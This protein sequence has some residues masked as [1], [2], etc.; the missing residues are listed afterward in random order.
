M[1]RIFL[2]L[3]LLV[4]FGACQVKPQ[5]INYGSDSCHFCK[6]TIVDSQHAAEVVTVKGKV[7][8]Y[9]AI[10]CMMGDLREWDEPDVK[11]HLIADY[12]N[13]G[14]LKD[15]TMSYY[16]VSNGIPS[17]MGRFLT[18]FSDEEKRNQVIQDAGGEAYDWKQLQVFFRENP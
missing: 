6:M 1:Y 17:P 4:G 3:S 9:D 8:K 7:F 18:G 11:F 12:A 14:E 2:L 13:P 15:A 16:V 5:P 10:E